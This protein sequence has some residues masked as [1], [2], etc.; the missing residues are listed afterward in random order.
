MR[1][2]ISFD[3]ARQIVL[4][5][6]VR[7]GTETVSFDQAL[8]RTLAQHIVSQDTVPPFDNSAMD[9]FAVRRADTA[10][11]PVRLEIAADIP[12]GTEFTGT[13]EGGQAARIMTGAPVPDGTDAVVPVEKTRMDGD[14]GV[15]IDETPRKAAHIRRAGEEL[16]E[17][18]LVLESGFVV[19]PPVIGVFATLGITKLMV[20]AA[21]RVAI[22]ST[23]DELVAPH[24]KPGPGQ[25]RNSNGPALAAQTL[26][27]GGNPC[28][29]LHALDNPADI[30]RVISKAQDVDL[31]VFSGGVSMGEYDY[32]RTEL[33]NMGA[34]WEFWKVRQRPGKPLAFGYL[35]DIPV[36]G[37][38][39]NP[40]SSSICFEEYV[41]PL[42]AQMMG[43]ANVIRP[44]EPALLTMDTPKVEALYTFA[45]GVLAVSAGRPKLTVSIT[46]NQASN[47]ITSM[48]HADCILHLPEG[49]AE[50]PAGSH[51]M[52][53]RLEW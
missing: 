9:G 33:D 18:D 17:G 42:L 12:A 6:A 45:R 20:S 37:L 48:V 21:P 14:T 28:R 11:T 46:G 16:I 47:R 5:S 53:E 1:T 19:T 51:V 38:P 24:K 36:I 44:L 15:W 34:R 2:F 41:R 22:I 25:I 50:A 4:Q 39:G 26:S 13:I 27:A 30:R 29:I 8:G 40:V 43:R 52:I 3:E 7:T 32:V 31:I 49:L 23:G 10:E 35:N